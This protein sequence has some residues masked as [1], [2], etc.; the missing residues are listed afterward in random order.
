MGCHPCCCG[1]LETW[2]KVIAILQIIKASISLLDGVIILALGGLVAAAP[3]LANLNATMTR[4]GGM[5][6]NSHF[7]TTLPPNNSLSH[8]TSGFNTSSTNHT[9][10]KESDSAHVLHSIGAILIAVSIYTILEGLVTLILSI[11]LYNGASNRIVGKC[12]VWLIV[13]FILMLPGILFFLA[14]LTFLNL[15]EVTNIIGG[16]D[17]VFNAYCLWIVYAFISELRGEN[18]AHR[19]GLGQAYHEQKV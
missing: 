16:V 17:L 4:G 7:L 5:I 12:R 9:V 13:Q 3:S 14:G 15:D 19:I 10:A 1:S 2:T 18:L 6:S 8:F 11:I